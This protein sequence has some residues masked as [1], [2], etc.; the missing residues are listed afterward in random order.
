MLIFATDAENLFACLKRR[1]TLKRI[2]A[3]ETFCRKQNVYHEHSLLSQNHFFSSGEQ[4]GGPVFCHPVFFPVFLRIEKGAV[5]LQIRGL[6]HSVE[7]KRLKW[8]CGDV[9]QTRACL[10]VSNV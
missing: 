2:I 7:L 4:W 1:F 3:A 10:R 6:P 8:I 9:H 5:L